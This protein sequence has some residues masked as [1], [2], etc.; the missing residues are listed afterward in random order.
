MTNRI[1][2]V[3][4]CIIILVEKAK[5]SKLEYLR[6]KQIKRKVLLW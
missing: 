4:V 3:S 1:W 2:R 6:L 5:V